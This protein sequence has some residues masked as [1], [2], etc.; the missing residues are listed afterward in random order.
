MAA[1]MAALYAC[2]APPPAAA[3]EAKV[4]TKVETKGAA[5]AAEPLAM[6]AEA[7]V[8]ER[9]FGAPLALQETLGVAEVLSNPAPYFGKIVQCAGI[10]ARVCERAGCWLE[11]RPDGPA[12]EGLRVPMA[13]HAFFIPQDAVGRPAKVEGKLVARELGAAERAHLESEGL[14]AVGPLSLTATGVVVR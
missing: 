8:E 13:G 1:L 12:R 9:A 2:E 14:R 5:P 7:P 4:G 3:P 11:L 10:V 6:P